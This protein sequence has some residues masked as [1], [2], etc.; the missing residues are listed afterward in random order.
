MNKNLAKIEYFPVKDMLKIA[1]EHVTVFRKRVEV[2]GRDYQGKRLPA[3]SDGYKE[4][5]QRDMRI[6]RG[7]RKGQR[8]KGLE[9]IGLTTNAQKIG[10][11]Q[12]KLR[13]FTM[14]N[15]TKRKATKTYYEIGW[16]G[17]AASIVDWNKDKG[18]N[19]V[20]GIPGKEFDFI[21]N[22]LGKSVDKQWAKLQSK[23]IR[24]G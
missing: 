22:L 5:L 16:D 19:I 2:E 14:S 11:R 7:D 24:F 18:R 13:G 23:T 4:A 8:H 15:L 12:F 10:R 9:G 6:K 21:I 20:D 17:E 3:Y 1:G